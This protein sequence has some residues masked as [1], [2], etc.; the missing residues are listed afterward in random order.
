VNALTS[1]APWSRLSSRF[2]ACWNSLSAAS[3]VRGGRLQAKIEASHDY[4][5]SDQISAE[6]ARVCVCVREGRGH[7]GHP[8]A[9]QATNGS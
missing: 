2:C 5:R 7:L 8:T 3:T 4:A 1:I 6:R 9:S